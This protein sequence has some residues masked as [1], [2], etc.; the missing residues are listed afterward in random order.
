[1]CVASPS[2]FTPVF[3]LW[4]QIIDFCGVLYDRNHLVVSFPSTRASLVSGVFSFVRRYHWQW[5]VAVVE[6]RGAHV[7]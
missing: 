3:A 2:F 5:T 1:M 7:L 4:P 6:I